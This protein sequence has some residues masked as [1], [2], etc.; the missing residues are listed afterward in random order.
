MRRLGSE[1]SDPRTGP[2]KYRTAMKKL[3]NKCKSTVI[4]PIL[5]NN[6]LITDAQRKCELFNEYFRDQCTLLNNSSTL[7]F[8]ELKTHHKISDIDVTYNRV[9]ELIRKLNVNKSHGHDGISARMIKLFDDSLVLPLVLIFRKCISIGRFP[10][11]WKMANVTAV[12]K[13]NARNVISNYRPI[14]LLP[15]FGKMLEKIV[16][17]SLYPHLFDNNLI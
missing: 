10:K 14:S 16:H 6:V 12:H 13:K 4:P 7:P 8:F 1:V 15:L 11:I 2:K 17:D 5:L 3:L 9:R